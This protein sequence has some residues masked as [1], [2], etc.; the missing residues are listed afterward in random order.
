MEIRIAAE[1]ARQRLEIENPL[2]LPNEQAIQAVED[3]EKTEDA[4]R[5]A[6][7]RGGRRAASQTQHFLSG[8]AQF[9]GA[10]NGLLETIASAAAPFGTVGYQTLSILLFVSVNNLFN[11]EFWLYK[12]LTLVNAMGRRS[13]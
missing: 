8:F 11:A 12:R 6:R 2:A 4:Y 13:P 5:T 3:A 1:L 9:V 10:F 7:L